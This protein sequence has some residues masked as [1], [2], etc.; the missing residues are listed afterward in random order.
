MRFKKG[1]KVEVLCKTAVSSGSWRPAEIISA[2]GNT[3]NVRYN[4]SSAGMDVTMERVP[5]KFIRPC[6]P[7]IE[8]PKDWVNGDIVEVFENNAWKLAE[9]SQLDGEHYFLVR[10]LGSSKIVRA[11]LPD[12]R[13]RQSW[14]SD[15]WVVIQKDYERCNRGSMNSQTKFENLSPLIPQSCIEPEKYGGNDEIN[16]GRNIGVNEPTP[17]CA[18]KRPS[19][20]LMDADRY[21]RAGN[22]R[23]VVKKRRC[24]EVTAG[25]SSVLLGKVDAV[26]SPCALL[27]EKYM[28]A[29]VN[30]STGLLE[31]PNDAESVSSSI[32]SCSPCY[33]PYRSLHHPIR[34]PVRN[35]DSH[36]DDSEP[37]CAVGREC[38]HYEKELEEQIHHLELKAYHSTMLAFYA[39]GPLSWKKE[40]FITNLRLALHVSNDEHLLVLRHLASAF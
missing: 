32:G 39:S 38:P 23:S 13:V 16:L 26:A 31:E 6:P 20:G 28:H 5:R 22:K 9:V 19:Y 1:S 27:G 18:K 11:H 30:Q 3:Y 4:G 7:L 8:G 36:Y 35:L 17:G 34:S 2:N 15:K 21:I 37:S 29:S 24:Q 40:E 14:I 10:L 33:S 12:L 25:N